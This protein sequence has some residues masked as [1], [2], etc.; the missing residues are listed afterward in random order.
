MKLLLHICCAPC[1][2]YVID[3]LKKE[4]SISIDGYFYNPNIHPFDEYNK[5]KK[6]LIDYSEKISL[7]VKYEDDYL[8]DKWSKHGK[9]NSRCQMC[10]LKRIEKTVKYAKK[11]GYDA[12][13]TT[14]LVSPYQKHEYLKT[15]CYDMAKKHGLFFYY[16][17]FRYGFRKGQNEARN[18]GLYRQKYC[19]CIVSYGQND[20]TN[21]V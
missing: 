17:D 16:K 12:F 14:L 7:N 19:G 1:S 4:N 8:E 5:R 10:Y 11:K 6:T 9:A 3:D 2:V 18:I 13:T 20:N 15:L 21:I